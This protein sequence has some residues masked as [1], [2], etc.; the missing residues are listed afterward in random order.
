[1]SEK[2]E[3]VVIR[4][5]HKRLPHNDALGI[6]YNRRTGN[7]DIGAIV[8]KNSKQEENSNAEEEESTLK[9]QKKK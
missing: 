1:M 9:L 5:S 8:N 4:P 3:D 6:P 7:M 2:E